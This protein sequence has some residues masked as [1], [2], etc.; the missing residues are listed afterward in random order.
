MGG[1]ETTPRTSLAKVEGKRRVRPSGLTIAWRG[2]PNRD[3]WVAFIATGGAAKKLIMAHE[4]SERRV[5]PLLAR[6]EGRSKGEIHKLA[7]GY[8]R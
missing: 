1:M 3:G 2:T 4:P 8:L 6:M 5:T 7:K